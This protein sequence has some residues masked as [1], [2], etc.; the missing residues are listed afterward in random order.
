MGIRKHHCNL[1]I[2]TEV[3]VIER[4][5]VRHGSI[6]TLIKYRYPAGNTTITAVYNRKILLG[7]LFVQIMGNLVADFIRSNFGNQTTKL[8]HPKLH[9]NIQEWT[10]LTNFAGSRMR[11]QCK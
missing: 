3:K 5:E 9:L 11:N 7:L 8:T 1:L 10:Q 2:R 4:F 6:A